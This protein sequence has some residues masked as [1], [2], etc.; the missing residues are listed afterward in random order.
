MLGAKLLDFW[1]L[2]VNNRFISY[3]GEFV[4]SFQ[5]QEGKSESHW[6]PLLISK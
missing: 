1:Y 2:D 4:R 6:Q 3:V 5:G